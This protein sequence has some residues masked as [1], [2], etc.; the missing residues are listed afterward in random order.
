MS[1]LADRHSGTLG[2]RLNELGSATEAIT[3]VI[4]SGCA[5]RPDVQHVA[6]ML[7]NLLSR[8]EG[9]VTAIELTGE[10]APLIERV[11]PFPTGTAT[12]HA[13]LQAAAETIGAVPASHVDAVGTGLVLNVGPGGDTD[14][15]RVHGE[16]FC[17]AIRHGPIASDKV[18]NL[19]IGPYIAASLAAGEVFRRLRISPE[20]YRPTVGLSFSAWDYTSGEGTIHDAGP[21]RLEVAVDFGLAGVGAVGCGLIHT[22]WACPDLTGAA[23][24][25]DS[26]KKGIDTTN[27]NRCVIFNRTHLGTR[28]A[29]AAGALC[30]DSG[31]VW[32]PVDGPY[33]RA[34]L[35]RIPT[36]IVSAVDTN[37]S[38]D[39]I[40]QGFWPARLLGAS[41]KDLRAE[42]LRCGSPGKGPCLRCYNPPET[43][44]PTE[45]RREQLRGMSETE[46]ESFAAQI[47]RSPALVRRW[48]LEGGCSEVA[49]TALRHM[50]AQDEPPSMFAVGFVSCLAGVLL[51]SELVKEHLGRPSALDDT[52]QTAKFQFWNPTATANGRPQRVVRDPKCPA[53]SPGQ[54]GVVLWRQ[55][56]LDW[57]PPTPG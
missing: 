31:I 19:P 42:I 49:D 44:V 32:E 20:R 5:R 45:V 1:E 16:G 33:A 23:V 21:D 48:A 30:A 50:R 6:W 52:R 11:I 38:R 24:I 41:T 9:I 37:R 4:E 27:L 56:T 12:L 7:V 26:D 51:A 8:M 15:L 36:L 54:P 43:D 34:G 57:R 55:R 2:G 53:C 10:D 39:Q 25:A 3:V 47:D 18:T 14:G 40:Q 46:L 22:L 17:G 28:K 13:A 29:T 35:P